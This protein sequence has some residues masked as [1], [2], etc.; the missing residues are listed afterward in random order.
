MSR[1]EASQEVGTGIAIVVPVFNDWESLRILV[2]DLSTALADQP[3]P[4][5]LLIVDDG[6]T[7]PESGLT[8]AVAATPFA[9]TLVRLVRN[10]GHQR[11][12]AIGLCHAVRLSVE[13]ILVMD[14]DGEDRPQDVPVLLR[15]L[16]D[17]RGSIIVA[18][19][20]RRSEG[21]RFTLFYRLYRQLFSLLTGTH[22]TFGN[23]SAMDSAVARRLTAMHELL[24]HVP[25]TMLRSRCRIVRVATDRGRRYA[26]LSKMNLVSLVVHGLSSVAVFSE[27]TFTRILLFS[28]GM[29]GLSA[30]ATVVAVIL[31]LAGMATPG[32]ATTVAGILMIVLVQNAAVALGGLFVVLNNNRDFALI[33]SDLADVFVAETRPIAAHPERHTARSAGMSAPATPSVRV[34]GE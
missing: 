28:A 20:G 29:F 17:N 32:W 34:Q 18:E 33:P 4:V 12:I 5:H 7:E 8:E 14:G 2:G 11:A 24:L 1:E 22:I 6:S 16:Q 9:C 21:L 3:R 31:K 25:A 30:L 27:R 19:R 13:D 26:G 23:F 10:V 15:A